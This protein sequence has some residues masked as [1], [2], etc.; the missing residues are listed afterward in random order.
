[1]NDQFEKYPLW[2][3]FYK[4][5]IGRFGW[6]DTTFHWQIYSL[7]LVIVLPL[8]ALCLLA[9]WR[10]R[11]V[12]RER[13]PELLAYGAIAGGLLVSIGLLGISYRYNTGFTFEQ[14]R[15]LLPLLPFYGAGVALAAR[16]AGARFERPLAAAIVVIAMA[17][18]LFA[19]LLVIARFYG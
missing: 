5:A 13:W 6:L 16:G 3:T 9:L 2:D 4:G 8:V 12:L 17:H 15:Y 7:S 11:R 1:M 19:Q 10:R 14:A 18:G